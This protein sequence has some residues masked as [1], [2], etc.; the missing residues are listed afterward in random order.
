MKFYVR[1]FF[2]IIFFSESYVYEIFEISV[3]HYLM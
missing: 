1:D 3:K 2:I